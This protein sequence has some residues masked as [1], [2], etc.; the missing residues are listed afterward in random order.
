[1]RRETSAYFVFAI[2]HSNISKVSA[3][4]HQLEIIFQLNVRNRKPII[5]SMFWNFVLFFRL[6]PENGRW[7]KQSSA[8]AKC[9]TQH[10]WCIRLLRLLDWYCHCKKKSFYLFLFVLRGIHTKPCDIHPKQYTDCNK[11]CNYA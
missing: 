3:A 4:Q 8:H 11:Q 2:I 7:R 10:E 9:H 6:P 5:L 1:M